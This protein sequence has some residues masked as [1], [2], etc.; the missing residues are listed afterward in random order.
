MNNN[1]A[2]RLGVNLDHLVTVRQAR[3]T[4]YP[5]LPEAIR[6]AE[7]AGADGITMH[8]REDRRHI[9][10][11]DIYQSRGLITTSMN[12]EMAATP[13]MVAIALEVKPD[14]CCIVPE[15]REELTT[16]GGL[17]VINNRARLIEVC[18]QLAEAGIKVS[19]F[20]EPDQEVID[21]VCQI[22]APIIE[23]HTGTYANATG[24][25]QSRELDRVIKAAEYAH[26]GGLQV[27]AGHGL[28]ND[29][30]QAIA[31]IGLI[32]EL[33]IGHAIIARALFVGLA[34]AVAEMKSAMTRTRK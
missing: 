3:R 28:S 26:Q 9:Q 16:E 10:T 32:K 20:I 13:E 21:A 18:G 19:M 11:E 14:Y 6:I 24:D 17:D 29:N 23:L 12:M 2:L 34:E 15:R 7:Q 25:E 33:N 1:N 22:A 8:L 5:E 4:P 27:N 30:V 31:A